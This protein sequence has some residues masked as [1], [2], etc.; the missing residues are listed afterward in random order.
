MHTVG[1]MNTVPQ[2]V[3][4]IDTTLYGV[5]RVCVCARVHTDT[6]MHAHA[7]RHTHSTQVIKTCKN[8][9]EIKFSDFHHSLVNTCDA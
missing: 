7:H 9:E 1:Y 2:L 8:N 6:H 4:I 5:Y 3:Q